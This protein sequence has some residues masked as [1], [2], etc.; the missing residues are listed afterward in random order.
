MLA[1]SEYTYRHDAAAKII[2]QEIAKKHKL[3]DD[4]TPYYKYIPNNILENEQYKLYWDIT[5]HTDKTI[6]Y[7]TPDITLQDIKQKIIKYNEKIEKYKELEIEIERIWHQEK[8]TI[9]PLIISTTGIT[10]NTFTQNL[11]RLQLNTNI[12]QTIQKSIVLKT[13]N[14]VRSFLNTNMYLM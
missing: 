1:G 13:C 14:I 10:P 5:M 12:H 3:I 4:E 2:H 7:N 8:V 6:P 11:K 9:I